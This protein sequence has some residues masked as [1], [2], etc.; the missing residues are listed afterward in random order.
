MLRPTWFDYAKDRAWL[1][2]ALAALVLLA[3]HC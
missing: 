1:L 3:T 2:L